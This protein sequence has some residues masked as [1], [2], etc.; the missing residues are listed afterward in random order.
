MRAMHNLHLVHPIESEQD[1]ECPTAIIDTFRLSSLA[2]TSTKSSLEKEILSRSTRLAFGSFDISMVEV[3]QLV[4]LLLEIV[5]LMC[6]ANMM[7]PRPRWPLIRAV[8]IW[9]KANPF[10]RSFDGSNAS[11]NS[12]APPLDTTAI[13]NMSSTSKPPYS[14]AIDF[15]SQTCLQK[16]S[17][18][19]QYTNQQQVSKT[20]L[21]K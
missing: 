15:T 17:Y 4:H 19:L 20:P 16:L 1:P 11:R 6:C 5:L 8:K 13:G 21:L 2:P 9:L 12:Q 7:N 3:P 14:L 18:N 10:T